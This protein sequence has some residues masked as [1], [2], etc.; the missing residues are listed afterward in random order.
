M[1]RI[2]KIASD[3]KLPLVDLHQTLEGAVLIAS[4]VYGH[5]LQGT[6]PEAKSHDVSVNTA[7]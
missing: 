6:P 2:R 3:E 5:L 4:L 1:P 7:K